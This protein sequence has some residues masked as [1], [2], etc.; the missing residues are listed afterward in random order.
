MRKCPQ[1][2]RTS[3]AVEGR[4]S[5]LSRLHHASRGFTEQSLTVLT[6]I[7]NFDLKRKDGTT[8]AQRLFDKQFPDLFE[9]VALNMGDLPRA[10][11]T[12]N[13]KISR[14]PAIQFVPA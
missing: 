12:L 6:I 14:K 2:Q 9:W 10:R 11:R 8:A 7:H 3:S 13:P 4:N 1:F 5:Y